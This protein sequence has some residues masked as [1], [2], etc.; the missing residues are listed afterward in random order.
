MFQRLEV[1]AGLRVLVRVEVGNVGLKRRADL[2]HDGVPHPSHADPLP[3][4]ALLQSG[5]HETHIK[6]VASESTETNR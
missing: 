6:P 4:F 1:G 5:E 2:R 3:Q